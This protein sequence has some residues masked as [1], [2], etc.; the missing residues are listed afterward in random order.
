MRRTQDDAM[1]RTAV[2]REIGDVLE[3]EG[4]IDSAA[5]E[6]TAVGKAV[7]DTFPAVEFETVTKTVGPEKIALRRAVLTGAWE[8]D[9]QGV[10]K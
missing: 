4:L 2:E 5:N 7:V 8:V 9:P 6:P 3:R 10:R 1:A